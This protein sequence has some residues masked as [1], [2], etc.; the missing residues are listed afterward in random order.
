MK[1]KTDI[2]LHDFYEEWVYIY[3]PILVQHPLDYI[4][5]MHVLHR[6]SVIS[7]L[8]SIKSNKWMIS[9]STIPHVCQGLLII[10]QSKWM[11]Y[12]LIEE[13]NIDKWSTHIGLNWNGNDL[14]ELNI[15]HTVMYYVFICK[16]WIIGQLCIWSGWQRCA[17]FHLLKWS[18]IIISDSLPMMQSRPQCWW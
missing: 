9:C 2:K 13:V 17:N 12:R 6:V 16:K 18:Q 4:E 1:L 7:S 11:Y 15:S 3:G 5:W 14:K 10:S 8:K